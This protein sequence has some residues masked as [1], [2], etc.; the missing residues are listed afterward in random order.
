[1]KKLLVFSMLTVVS[2]LHAGFDFGQC[3]GSGT[4]EQQIDAYG[5][6]NE[7]T[8]YVGAIPAGVKGLHIEL[9]SDKDVDIRLYGENNDKIVHWPNGILN[10]SG[11]ETKSYKNVPITYSGY[12]GT[13]HHPGH[14]FIDIKGTTP[15]AMT[16]KA[17]GYQAGYA[18]VN[19]SWTGKEG[20]EEGGG[21]GTGHFEQ[22]IPNSDIALVGSIPKD[23]ENLEVNLTSDKD[24]DI[25]LYGADGTAIVKWPD[26]LLK[27]AGKQTI[28]YHNMHIEWSGYNG[29]DG[30]AGHE[31]IKITGKTT[32]EITMKVYG[33]QAGNASVDYSW[34]KKKSLPLVIVRIEFL[35]YKFHSDA[36]TWHNKIFG[37]SHGELNDYMSEISN[38]TLQ[39]RPAKEED[40]IYNDGIITISLN[41]NHPNLGS[42]GDFS[43]EIKSALILANSKINFSAYDKNANGAISKDELQIMFLVAGGESAIGDNPGIWAHAWC[44]YGDNGTAP[45]H[46][47]VKLMSCVDDG[48]YSLFG[49]RHGNHD[50]TIGVIA[51]ELGHAVFDL[52]DLYDMDGSSSG[53]G[54][55]GLMAGGCWG[56]MPYGV[57]PDLYAGQTPVHMTGWSK[58]QSGFVTP[59]VV[60]SNMAHAQFNPTSTPEYTLYKVPTGH[61]GEYF[62]LEQRGLTGYDVGLLGVLNPVETSGEMSGGISILHI[63]ENMPD[64]DNENHKLVDVE[65]A[66][67]AELDS[68]WTD[69]NLNNLYYAPNADTFNRN[70]FPNSRRYGG[71][72]SG[73]SIENISNSYGTMSADILVN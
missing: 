71:Q 17:F 19:Y 22:D 31:Y 51:H 25:Q 69:G 61:K 53:I 36:T 60:T 55:F 11:L 34:G 20:C 29:V 49:E 40:G 24:I 41:E 46:D 4:F 62:L 8:V 47:G 12:N 39:Y 14:E 6:D 73:V 3:S 30:H 33:F 56:M 66:N 23:I 48:G 72:D 38:H 44:M 57:N 35:N 7:K 37:S 64:N 54:G 59:K 21:N 13:N 42:T 52:P 70:T 67:N 58:I 1:M 28:N 26:G 18:T 65:E 2:G 10:Q 15:T 43:N 50:A 5:G 9:N 16:M 27:G 63:D 32:E 45:I 68:P